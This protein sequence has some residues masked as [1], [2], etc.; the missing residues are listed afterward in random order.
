M[1]PSV[2]QEQGTSSCVQTAEAAQQ[3][4]KDTQ[5]KSTPE[6]AQDVSKEVS[7]TSMP[8]VLPQVV[9]DASLLAVLAAGKARVNLE[10]I[11]KSRYSGDTFFSKVIEKPKDFRNFEVDNGHETQ[12]PES[13]VYS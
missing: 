13:V 2:T 11:L 3:L 5:D 12:R 8:Q 6:S 9:N 4:M 7:I 10:N 1:V